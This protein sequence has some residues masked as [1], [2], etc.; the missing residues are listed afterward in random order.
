MN[1]ELN[2]KIALWRQKAAEGAMSAADYRAA[3]DQ[4]REGRRAA[5][6]TS[7]KARTTRARALKQVVS[8]DDLFAGLEDE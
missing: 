1:T 4:L 6:T 8:A 5:A 2:E 3:L 7:L